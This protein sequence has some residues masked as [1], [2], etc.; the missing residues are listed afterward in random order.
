MSGRE[1]ERHTEWRIHS[2]P[3]ASCLSQRGTESTRVEDA[4][5]ALPQLTASPLLRAARFKGPE[6]LIFSVFAF[7]LIITMTVTRLFKESIE[8]SCQLSCPPQ[9]VCLQISFYS[10]QVRKTSDH[11]FTTAFLFNSQK[12]LSGSHEHM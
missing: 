12:R 4:G 11:E 10:S 3:L 5:I 2:P 9:F 6:S 1:T 8:K 7:E